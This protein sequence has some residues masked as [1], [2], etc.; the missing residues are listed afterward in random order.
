M[1]DCFRKIESGRTASTRIYELIELTIKVIWGF[2]TLNDF[3]KLFTY[4]K[5]NAESIVPRWEFE[6]PNV[7]LLMNIE[8]LGT[9]K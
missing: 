8:K 1:S 7:K 5:E 2:D 6:S 3:Q 9:K 4:I